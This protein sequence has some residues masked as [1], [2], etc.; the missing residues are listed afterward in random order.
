MS[1]DWGRAVGL[2]QGLTNGL[3]AKK[4][5]RPAKWFVCFGTLLRMIRDK[6]NMKEGDDIDLGL[7]YEEF[8]QHIIENHIKAF[9]LEI[10]RMIINDVTKTPLYYGLKAYGTNI[11]ICIFLWY[12][13]KNI[14]YH[15]YDINREGKN[16][17]SKYIFK[18]VPAD[19]LEGDT[20]QM[21]VP[22]TYRT[23]NVPRGYGRLLDT[24]Y[25]DWLTKRKGQS[26]TKWQLEMKSCKQFE[27][28]TYDKVPVKCPVTGK[29][30]Q[31]G[32]E[33]KE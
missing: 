13:H 19:T 27:N 6:G 1:T 3:F 4:A 7:L 23:V 5:F 2:V 17:P 9:G 25:P 12:K 14:R 18:G 29:I 22:N 8:D 24:W 33:V 31:D 11:H 10:E 28:E 30:F 20:Q 15:T 16:V 26:S 32:V 21:P